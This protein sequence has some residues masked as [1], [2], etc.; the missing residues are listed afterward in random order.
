MKNVTGRVFLISLSVGLLGA[1]GVA[2]AAKFSIEAVE[3]NG[4]PITPT[5]NVLVNP[6]DTIVCEIFASEWSLVDEALL[7]SW[8]VQLDSSGY[9]N[10]GPGVVRPRG[11]ERPI[12]KISCLVNEDCPPE[13]P[14][15]LTDLRCTNEYHDPRQGA[16]IDSYRSDYIFYGLGEL[17]AVDVST[18]DYRY[19]S[20]LL[21]TSDCP[22]Y[23][24]P[25]HKYCGT[26]IL[27]V[28][29][30]ACG[31]FTIG[32]YDGDSEMRDCPYGFLIE[33][34]ELEGLTIDTQ[35]PC[36]CVVDTFTPENCSI[37][38]RQ[39]CNPDGSNTAGW[40]SATLRFN[41]GCNA[42]NYDTD[43][44]SVSEEPDSGNTIF[45]TSVN[46]I[47]NRTTITFNR[48]ITL[49]AWTCVTFLPTRYES[50]FGH[51]PADVTSDEISA[52]LDILW[53]IDCINGDETCKIHQ[54]DV[55]RSGVT[56]PPDILRVIDLLNGAGVYDPW[57][58]VLIP[59]CPTEP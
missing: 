51:L 11:W 3:V 9:S 22:L 21:Q 24:P 26:L 23:N 59:A 17:K 58:D 19:G 30:N 48:R 54:G 44:F 38:A 37:D 45:V 52:P 49:G 50:C 39:P 25:H 32:M 2:E 27:D 46:P 42:A 31:V 55:D 43:D 15:C 28:D 14:I 5:N 8:Q 56:G 20:S 57:L 18:L 7:K 41:V 10:V 6:G 29:D 33:P 13:Y 12:P 35:L 40:N 47:I 34:L 1:A 53:V 36:D 16:F 4:T